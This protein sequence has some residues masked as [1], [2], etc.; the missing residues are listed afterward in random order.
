MSEREIERERAREIT[1]YYPI[2][3]FPACPTL[4]NAQYVLASLI[5]FDV[6]SISLHI[7]WSN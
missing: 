6:K 5:V 7:F 2:K 1:I 4:T 3:Y